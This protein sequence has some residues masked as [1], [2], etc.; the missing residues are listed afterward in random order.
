MRRCRDLEGSQCF[1]RGG[2]GPRRRAGNVAAPEPHR[3]YQN[4]NSSMLKMLFVHFKKLKKVSEE[5][6][7][8]KKV[9]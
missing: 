2:S 4:E 3:I 5:R 6:K 7:Y 9:K 8:F 1:G